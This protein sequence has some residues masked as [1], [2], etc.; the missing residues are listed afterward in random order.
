MDFKVFGKAIHDQF[1]KMKKHDLFRVD[2]GKK[3]TWEMY[4]SSFPEGTNPI[5]KERTEHDCV[6]CRHFIRDVGR[7]VF[8]ENNNLVS[9]WDINIGGYYQVVADAMAEWVKGHAISGPLSCI[10]IQVGAKETLQKLENGQILTWNHF[11][12]EVP[13]EHVGISQETL[14][15]ARATKQVFK[16]GLD[17][18]SVSAIDIV[19]ELIDQKSLYK[20][21]EFKEQIDVFSRMKKEYGKIDDA[22]FAADIFCWARYKSKGARIRNTVVG[23]LLQDI[24]DGVNL[25]GAV[26]SYEAKVAP[27]NYKRPT[28]LITKRMVDDAMKTIDALGIK[29]SLHRRYAVAEDL[30]VNNVLFADRN[31]AK[32]MKDDI[33]GSLMD[34]VRTE[35]KSYSKVEEISMDNFMKLIPTITQMEVMLEN[36]HV[37]NLMSITAPSNDDSPNILKWDNNFS[38]SYNGDLTDSIREKVK[39][40][41]GNVEGF[42]RVSLSWFNYDDLDIHVR[43]PGGNRIYFSNPRNVITTGHLDVDMNAGC[44]TTRDPVENIVWTGNS[45]MERG[46]YEVKVHNFHRRE[47]SKVGFVVEMEIN[48]NVTTYS[49]DRAVGDSKCVSVIDFDFDGSKVTSISVKKDIQ[50]MA[51][52]QDLW[53]VQTEKFQKVSLATLSPNHW[54]DSRI[55]NKHYF[56]ILDGCRNPGRTRG[57]YNEFLRTGLE[58]HRKVFE[59]LG[60]KTKC[61]ESDSQ[62]SGLGFSSTKRDSIICK[63]S[64]NFNRMLKINF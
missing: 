37:K 59:V 16:R 18:I 29:Q 44:G 1:E 33:L 55:G 23:T 46:K 25:D 9:I 60:S 27:T 31:T 64:G 21:D 32:V 54:D 30:S 56:F 28:A 48:G 22:A 58:K 63:V 10:T 19:L 6:C 36:R 24:S 53:N 26:S 45:R 49:Y 3:D 11:H 7:A 12:A 20:G 42:L 38:W 40:A 47:T 34:E 35:P 43:E 4:L 57:L 39:R 50:G 2:A 8:I 13:K 52:S 62:L 5:Y 17:E 41:G 15:G 51:I 14:S 61:E